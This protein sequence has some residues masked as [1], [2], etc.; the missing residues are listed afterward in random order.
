MAKSAT[1]KKFDWDVMGAD[2][3]AK[4]HAGNG[5]W[6]ESE[7]F[8]LNHEKA[9]GRLTED[10]VS[11]DYSPVTIAAELLREA[12]D[13]DMAEALLRYVVMNSKGFEPFKGRKSRYS[14]AWQAIFLFSERVWRRFDISAFAMA[15]LVYRA[16]TY[17]DIDAKRVLPSQKEIERKLV[18]N[19]K[20]PMFASKE[21]GKDRVIARELDS[22]TL[23][24]LEIL[25]NKGG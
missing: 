21:N 22:F 3:W 25:R 20:R 10:H 8:R 16:C 17:L 14:S 1:R 23:Q 15:D 24:A 13:P 4:R 19:F 5:N 2:L 7:F 12:G 9:L 11:C 18:D 6:A